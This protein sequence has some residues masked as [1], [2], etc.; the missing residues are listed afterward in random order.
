M[1]ISYQIQINTYFI[2]TTAKVVLSFR[3]F[4]LDL[5]SGIRGTD[6]KDIFQMVICAQ[7]DTKILTIFLLVYDV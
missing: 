1:R 4:Y 2:T 5:K 3:L 7:S 6:A